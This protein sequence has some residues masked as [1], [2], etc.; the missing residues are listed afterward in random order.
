MYN[1]HPL[2]RNGLP[3]KDYLI[4][5]SGEGEMAIQPDSASVNL[6]IITESKQVITAQQQNSLEVTKVID[7]LISLGITKN[8]IQTFD[9]RIESDYD[10]DQGK[11]IFRG[12]KITHI[13]Q[14]KIEDLSIVGKV[15]DTAVQNGVNY[16]SNVQFT[17][18]NKESFYKQV[19]G[20]A[21]NNAIE[22]AK[23][24]AGTLNVS[25][26]PTPRLVIEGGRTVQPVFNQPGA[27]VKGAAS[28]L[29]EPGQITVKADVIAEFHFKP[30]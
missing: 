10:Y 19:L 20:M 23:T 8:N 9:Y 13:L 28:T 18:K 3:P 17:V 24:I 11:Q 1:Y 5:V 6:G 14:V 12:Y 15:V 16:V 29:I 25:L 22:K 27:F 7:S 21:V 26:I 4:K 30:F 2:S